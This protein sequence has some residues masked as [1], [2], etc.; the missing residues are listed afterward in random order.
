MKELDAFNKRV[1]ELNTLLSGDIKSVSSLEIVA[2]FR[3]LRYEL[4]EL[5]DATLTAYFNKG[6]NN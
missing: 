1:S 5:D 2:L 6:D 3:D 4:H